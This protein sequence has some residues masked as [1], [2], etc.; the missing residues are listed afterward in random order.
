LK[1]LNLFYLFLFKKFF[2]LKK[3]KLVKQEIITNKVKIKKPF[4]IKE[5]RIKVVKNKSIE[6]SV[7]GRNY[8][9]PKGYLSK[10]E[11]AFVSSHSSLVFSKSL[12]ICS[13]F[14][15]VELEQ[16][17][18]VIFNSIKLCRTKKT[19]KWLKKINSFIHI[20][21]AAFFSKPCDTNYAH[22]IA[23]TLPII[24]LFCNLEKYKKIPLIVNSNLHPNMMTA[25]KLISGNRVIFKISNNNMMYVK[26]LYMLSP[27]SHIPF[28]AESCN[29]D[30]LTKFDPR[31][32][33]AVAIF[34][35]S[36][37]LQVNKNKSFIFPDKIYVKRNSTYRFI[38]NEEEII[39][40]VKR[41]GYIIIEPEKLSF[42]EQASFFYYAK[43]IIGQSGAG[44]ANCIFSRKG[45]VLGIFINDHLIDNS[46][47][48]KLLY[49][50]KIDIYYIQSTPDSSSAHANL[51]VPIST[52][53]TYLKH[54]G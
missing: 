13:D 37:I 49:F 48:P 15:R 41:S 22:F 42:I 47:W 44:L 11:N 5:S 38:E 21:E 46:F 3:F 27:L 6:N 45:T 53:E 9:F 28:V 24:F 50:N 2:L 52:I 30:K 34:F 29:I 54:L 51:N 35:Q 39:K 23:N 1:T 20:E 32:L 7:V 12:A 25:I 4:E 26:S 10:I 16:M 36:L 40:I 8:H 43:Q 17:P 19:V 18:E 31:S 14:L 33:S